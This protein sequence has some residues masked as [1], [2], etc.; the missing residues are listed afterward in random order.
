MTSMPIM[1]TGV[2][3]VILAAAAVVQG[4]SPQPGAMV[5]TTQQSM[6]PANRAFTG[7][8]SGNDWYEAL[9][10]AMTSDSGGGGE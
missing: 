9:D 2:A 4:C 5:A 7:I 8:Y 1:R 10:T 6:V 3:A